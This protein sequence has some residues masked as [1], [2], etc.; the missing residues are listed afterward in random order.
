MHIDRQTRTIEVTEYVL[1]GLSMK[2]VN[3]LLLA[4]EDAIGERCPGDYRYKE[5]TELQEALKIIRDEPSDYWG[6]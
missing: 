2:D 3:T 6:R 4:V 1:A 5:L